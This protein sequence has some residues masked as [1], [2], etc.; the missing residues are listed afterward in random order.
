MDTMS[1]A[2][3]RKAESIGKWEE[4]LLEITARKADGP[5]QPLEAEPQLRIATMTRMTGEES[6][7]RKPVPE[8][9]EFSLSHSGLQAIDRGARSEIEQSPMH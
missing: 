9:T 6:G 3:A 2:E 5:V 4:E 7:E 1:V 8:A